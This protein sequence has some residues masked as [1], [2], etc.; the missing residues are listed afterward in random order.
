MWTHLRPAPG[1]DALIV[2]PDHA[3][4]AP[5][6]GQ[7][8]EQLELRGVGVLVLVDQEISIA[9]LVRLQDLGMPGEEP[10]RQVQQVVKVD[11]SHGAQA[12]LVPGEQL[13]GAEL[14]L[15]V[16]MTRRAA[17][18]QA[19]EDGDQPPDVE[20]LVVDLH[21]AQQPLRQG[22]LV[23]GV[24][25]GELRGQA[26]LLVLL[27]NDFQTESVEGAH[28]HPA[29]VRGAARQPGDALFHLRRG[30]V[31][32]GDREDGARRHASLQQVDHPVRDDPRL[33]RAGAGQHQHRPLGPHDRLPLLGIEEGKVQRHGR[34][35]SYRGPPA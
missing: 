33:A 21:L 8:L 31:G 18:A 30:L 25:H 24:E 7:L 34:G 28:Q 35:R 4:I 23:S 29:R 15:V 20:A 17:R 2:V 13:A 10:Q 27:A 32:E 16:G 6:S 11:R 3:E 14:V 22:R 12:Q 19:G 9:G 5:Q 26:Q 1:V